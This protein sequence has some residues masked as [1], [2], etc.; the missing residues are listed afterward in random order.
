MMKRKREITVGAE[1]EF[2]VAQELRS[3]VGSL[4][5]TYRVVNTTF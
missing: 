2:F 5:S 4:K 1:V 3:T